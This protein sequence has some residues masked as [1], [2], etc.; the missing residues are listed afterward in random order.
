MSRR[1]LLFGLTVD[2][3]IPV[4]APDAPDGPIDVTIRIG[5]VPLA[6]EGASVRNPVLG[7]ES[8]ERSVLLQIADVGRFLVRDGRE[9]VVDPSP[10]APPSWMLQPLLSFAM[11]IVLQWRGVLTLHG[12][13]VR[14]GD[15]AVLLTGPR[16]RGKS[17]LAAYLASC[18]HVVQSDGFA[19]I[20]DTSG[21]PHVLGGPAAQNLWPDAMQC[22]GLAS[23]H[24][25]LAPT[26][27][28]RFVAEPWSVSRAA[29]PLARIYVLGSDEEGISGSFH[30]TRRV[31][32]VVSQLFM[33]RIAWSRAGEQ[34]ARLLELVRVCPVGWLARAPGPIETSLRQM[35]A[36]VLN[37][38]SCVLRGDAEVL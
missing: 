34:A 1:V 37:S 12:S 23:G 11:A 6:L 35:A 24:P 22:L 8:D 30:G 16:G 9:I 31:S 20:V 3:D 21:R 27:D 26:T 13:A 38:T 2:T 18:G 36:E 29:V 28:K 4:P 33:R 19:A 5:S 7:F 25:T 10:G 32:A 17:T 15:Q 14:V